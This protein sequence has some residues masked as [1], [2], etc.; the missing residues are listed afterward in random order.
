MEDR[1]KDY[2]RGVWPELRQAA[3]QL[4]EGMTAAE[5]ALWEALRDRKLGGLRFRA[6]HPVGQFILDFY[7]PACKLAVELDGTSHE[8][9]AAE[10]AART[11][12]LRAYGYRVFRF[13]NEE[14]LTNS[15]SVT[16]R[17]LKAAQEPNS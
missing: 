6:Q 2:V 17:I 1:Q 4:R 5:Q 15:A 12:H 16:E 14:A 10:D 7:W 3:T 8:G 13:Q 11:A 9:R